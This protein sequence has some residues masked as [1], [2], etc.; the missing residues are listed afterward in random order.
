MNETQLKDLKSLTNNRLTD[1]Q[2]NLVFNYVQTVT[3]DLTGRVA[4]CC[5]C[6]NET[7]SRLEL[8]FF[9]YQ[10][11]EKHDRYYCGCRGWE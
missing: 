7:P 1:S 11:T 8:P 3:A 10:P 4:R 5:D 2:L 9:Q 6:K